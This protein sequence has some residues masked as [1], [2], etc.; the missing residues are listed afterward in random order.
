M[1][2]VVGFALQ[3]Q[4]VTEARKSEV[5]AT[6][7]RAAVDQANSPLAVCD[8]EGVIG[9]VNA[10]FLQFV[11]DYE[12]EFRKY[13]RSFSSSSL[14]GGNLDML[15]PDGSFS[16]TLR[17]L[18]DRAEVKVEFASLEFDLVFSP[19]EEE[20]ARRVLVEVVD[21]TPRRMYADQVSHVVSALQQ[22]DVSVRGDVSALPEDYQPDAAECELRHRHDCGS[23]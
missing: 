6:L 4:N 14:L 15:W 20:G 10:S 16:G 18:S 22:G 1:G 17:S 2:E 19:V 23:H 5:E 11:Y 21:N 3:W 12:Q 8:R 9:H 13:S 7:M